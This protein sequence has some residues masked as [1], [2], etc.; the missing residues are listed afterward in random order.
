MEKTP[1][2]KEDRRV[3]LFFKFIGTWAL[4]AFLAA[5]MPQNWI[6]EIAEALG[7][8]PFPLSPLTFYLARN[9][10]LMYGFVGLTLWLIALQ[11][12][13]HRY[14]TGPIAYGT[15]VFGTLKGIVDIQSAMPI[16][17]ILYESLTTIGGGVLLAWL[18]SVARRQA[19]RRQDS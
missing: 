19:R 17:W 11:Y 3:L 8:E 4:V 16:W 5:I 1:I 13:R 18:H 12:E 6:V 14:L 15:F 10:S 7:F 2:S 9:L